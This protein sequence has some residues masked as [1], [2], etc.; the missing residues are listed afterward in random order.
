MSKLDALKR[1]ADGIRMVRASDLM[2]TVKSPDVMRGEDIAQMWARTGK[3]IK[4]S[5]Q[6]SIATKGIENPI[7][8]NDGWLVDGHHRLLAAFQADPDMLV[9]VKTSGFSALTHS[10]QPVTKREKLFAEYLS[11]GRGFT[12]DKAQKLVDQ[13]G[14]K[15]LVASADDND[16]NWLDFADVWGKTL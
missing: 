11:S 2:S 15:K 10:V 12:P 9:P 3:E 16:T 14:Y 5:F 7:T 4:P 13:M 6:K 1:M 8:M